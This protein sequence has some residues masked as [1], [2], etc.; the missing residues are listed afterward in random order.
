LQTFF[1]H[2]DPVFFG[3]ETTLSGFLAGTAGR[4]GAI[5]FDN[6]PSNDSMMVRDAAG[7]GGILN[8]LRMFNDILRRAR[9]LKDFVL[10]PPCATSITNGS[11]VFALRSKLMFKPLSSVH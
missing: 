7:R 2:V 1:T 6:N 3:T 9:D 10:T 8:S 11:N 5:D 4:G